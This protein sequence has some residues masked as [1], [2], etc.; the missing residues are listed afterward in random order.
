MLA[1]TASALYHP[2]FA[3]FWNFVDESVPVP[4]IDFQVIRSIS[5]CKLASNEKSIVANFHARK[6]GVR[7]VYLQEFK[8]VGDFV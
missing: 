2:S 7:E 5:V 8:K 3:N 1:N 6:F 4:I